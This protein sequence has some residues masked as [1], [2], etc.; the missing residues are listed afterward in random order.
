MTAMTNCRRG[1]T[2]W[3]T[4]G[5]LGSLMSVWWGGSL[6]NALAQQ[7]DAV[8]TQS[9]GRIM[10]REG[11]I[12]WRV[13]PLQV[14]QSGTV[15]EGEPEEMGGT[16][17][18]GLI[19]STG[20]WI[21]LENAEQWVVTEGACRRGTDVGISLY[22]DV[23]PQPGYVLAIAGAQVLPGEDRTSTNTDG[24]PVII[25]PR[26]TTLLEPRPRPS[27]GPRCPKRW[28]MRLL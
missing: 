8:L 19:C 5:L 20:H 28:N 9:K 22:R 27:G 6:A 25:S 18:A 4:L 26:H 15:L 12:S 13:H 11:T 21:W 17:Q 10:V 7:V 1:E 14:L 3:R 16:V 2:D 23:R 24:V